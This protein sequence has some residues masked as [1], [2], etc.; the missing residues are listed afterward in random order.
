MTAWIDEMREAEP[1]LVALDG[2]TARRTHARARGCEPLHLV[3]AWASRQRLVL[4]Q[5]AIE[6]K[7]NEINAIPSG[8]AAVDGGGPDGHG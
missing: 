3:S 4:G 6:A 1:N 7:T 2:K 5:A 8:P